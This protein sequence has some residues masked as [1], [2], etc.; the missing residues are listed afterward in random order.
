MMLN[1]DLCMFY[2]DNKN[3]AKCMEET[4]NGKKRNSKACRHWQK[5]GKFLNAL[6]DNKPNHCCTWMRP[7]ALIKRGI[8]GEDLA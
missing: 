5:K 2:Q 8:I 7:A 6:E 1:T 4:H 3:H